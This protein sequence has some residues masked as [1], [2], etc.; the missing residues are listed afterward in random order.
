[1]EFVLFCFLVPGF[2]SAYR[3]VT[4]YVLSTVYYIILHRGFVLGQ[5]AGQSWARGGWNLPPVCLVGVCL[6]PTSLNLAFPCCLSV[7]HYKPSIAWSALQ[8]SLW[9]L[10]VNTNFSPTGTSDGH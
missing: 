4:Y 2:A 7:Y 6:N 1:M 3:L 8:S 10:H 9:S 5:E